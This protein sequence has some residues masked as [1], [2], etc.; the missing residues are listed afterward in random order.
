MKPGPADVQY[1]TARY[2]AA[3][4]YLSKYPYLDEVN[5]EARSRL[6]DIF[7]KQFSL[8]VLAD[9]LLEAGM[10]EKH[11]A[12]AKQRA[13]V[14]GNIAKIL[15]AS[16]TCYE[17]PL[18]CAP[19]VTS[20]S[21]V[22]VDE[23]AFVLPPLPAASFRLMTSSKGVWSRDESVAYMNS[24][25]EIDKRVL[26]AFTACASVKSKS[27]A[28]TSGTMQT[29]P[30]VNGSEACAP[31]L[32]GSAS[33]AAS[34]RHTLSDLGRNEGASVV[35]LVEGQALKQADFWFEN[36]VLGTIP[37]VQGAGTYPEKFSAGKAI[38]VVQTT[39]GNPGWQDIN[40]G[41]ARQSLLKDMPIA[42]GI[43]YITV[44][45]GF[46][47]STRFDIE[48]QNWAFSTVKSGGYTTTSESFRYKNRWWDKN[49]NGTSIFGNDKYTNEGSGTSSSSVPN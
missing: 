2:S 6:Q 36:R 19:A 37:L 24:D 28:D 39:R 18:V 31:L 12:V 25:T 4:I 9:R 48:Y 32:A 7:E 16:R 44:K 1:K 30:S 33:L 17:K 38:I 43:F 29:L 15:D 26:D 49:S 46:G 45:D 10:G 20:L 42:D 27:S 14:D 21:L 13:I 41:S 3:G 5:K 23:T 22:E 40:T 34:R 11:D 8:M 47:R 35:I